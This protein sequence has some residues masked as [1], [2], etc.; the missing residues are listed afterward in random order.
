MRFLFFV[1]FV[2]L[3]TGHVDAHAIS[4]IRFH[5]SRISKMDFLKGA[6]LNSEIAMSKILN[7]N[8]N[9]GSPDHSI[10]H[11]GFGGV[12]YAPVRSFLCSKTAKLNFQSFEKRAMKRKMSPGEWTNYLRYMV[13]RTTDSRH[14]FAKFSRKHRKTMHR[15]VLRLMQETV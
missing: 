12:A 4:D 3:C 6:F 1:E 2:S 8:A 10:A 9:V 13:L 15:N 14:R 7:E 11:N 5:I